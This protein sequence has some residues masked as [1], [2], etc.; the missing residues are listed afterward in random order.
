MV[1][2]ED[3]DRSICRRRVGTQ[4]WGR[5]EI[6][7]GRDGVL[8]L[9]VQKSQG[10]PPGMY[11]PYRQWDELPFP[12]LVNAGFQASTVGWTHGSDRNDRS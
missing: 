9:M 2:M 10:Q 1:G 11:K 8:L 12:Q 3:D 4:L 6:C 7:V 5:T